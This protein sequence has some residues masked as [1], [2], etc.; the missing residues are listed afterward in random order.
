MDRERFARFESFLPLARAG[1]QVYDRVTIVKSYK[2]TKEH[3]L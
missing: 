2:D 3:K 1:L